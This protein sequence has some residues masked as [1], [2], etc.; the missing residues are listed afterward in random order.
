M[1]PH[2]R[3]Y[4]PIG[5]HSAQTPRSGR[6]AVLAQDLLALMDMGIGSALLAG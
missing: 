4:G 1:T 5:F 2:L 6:Q 3:G